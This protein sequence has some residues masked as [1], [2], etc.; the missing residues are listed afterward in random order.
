MLARFNL[1]PVVA[2]LVWLAILVIVIFIL[3]IVIHAFGGFDWSLKIGDF[4]LVVGV[5]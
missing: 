1:P 3:A 4:R 5:T 2:F